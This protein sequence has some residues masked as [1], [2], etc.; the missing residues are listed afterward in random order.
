[1]SGHQTGPTEA[2]IEALGRAGGPVHVS[3]LESLGVSR[4]TLHRLVKA[5]RVERGARGYYSLPADGDDERVHWAAISMAVPEVVFCMQS[6]A[7][8]HGL[9]QNLAAELDLA[10][11]VK[12]SV[13]KASFTSVRARWTRWSRDD[14]FVQGVTTVEIAGTPVRVTD[15]E[16]T[17][18]D[19]F[20]YSS[21]CPQRRTPSVMVDDETVLDAI[22]RYYDSTEAD[23]ARLG[24]MAAF[25]GVRDR[26]APVLK[27]AALRGG[28]PLPG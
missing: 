27:M 21:L 11:P 26:I 6:A 15:R 17:V 20:R 4:V 23:P 3:G 2:A 18:I 1:M 7:A 24:S 10:I 19:L 5:G 13:P 14:A 16:R 25:F 8:Y 22:A 9:T 28:G 12:H